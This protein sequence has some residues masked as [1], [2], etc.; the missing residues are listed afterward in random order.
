M[1]GGAGPLGSQASC[2]LI[3]IL[4]PFGRSRTFQVQILE[5][6]EAG[7][8][9]DTPHIELSPWWEV[10]QVVVFEA[11]KGSLALQKNGR[12]GHMVLEAF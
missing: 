1:V 2:T 7:L 4:N 10:S 6:L 11:F 9:L 8:F 12:C 5:D 3:A